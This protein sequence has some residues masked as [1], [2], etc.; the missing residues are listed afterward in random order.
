MSWIDIPFSSFESAAERPSDREETLNVVHLRDQ[1]VRTAA[2]LA[3][4]LEIEYPGVIQEPLA[5][6]EPVPANTDNVVPIDAARS[7]S[8]E[9]K[10]R[11]VEHRQNPAVVQQ[12]ARHAL[13][14]KA[15]S[16]QAHEVAI[17]DLTQG[18]RRIHDE[19]TTGDQYEAAA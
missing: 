15:A 18:V 14:F 1:V 12:I 11:M 4:S 8:P 17:H 19:D 13:D 2:Y 3:G 9:L 7:A 10:A 6:T 16:D 5:Q